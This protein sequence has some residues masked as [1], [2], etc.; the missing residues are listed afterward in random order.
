MDALLTGTP[1]ESWLLVPAVLTAVIETPLFWLCGYRHIGQCA[2]FMAVNIQTNLLLNEFLATQA[3]ALYADW[4]V[5]LCEL[6]VV[7][8]EFAL[9]RSVVPGTA[10]HLWLTLLTTNLSS[11]G[12]GL[13]LFRCM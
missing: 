13:V 6:V 12:L 9:C 2:W 5:V 8:L 4:L 1:L 10:K 3:D 11:Y 7:L